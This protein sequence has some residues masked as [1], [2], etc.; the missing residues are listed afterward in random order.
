MTMSRMRTLLAVSFTCT[1][2]W[3][4]HTNFH[5]HSHG[6][7]WPTDTIVG[8]GH[9]VTESRPV[10]G[11]SAISVSSAAR[12]VIVQ[13]DV[14]SLSVTAEDNILPLVQAEVVG[15]RLVLGLAAHSSISTTREIVFQVSAR[16]VSAID[17]TGATRVEVTN[18]DADSV[19]LHVSGASEVTAAGRVKDL[20]VE[21]SGSVRCQLE[22]LAS[23][24]AVADVSGSSY[25]RLRVE[26][27]LAATASGTSVVEY[28]GN[29][30]VVANV[31]GL[32]AVRR[33]GS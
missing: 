32:S 19:S 28:Y 33:L 15:G 9:V 30:V 25:A 17:A 3:G 20:R 14:E 22:G 6:T 29:P 11:F 26:D 2:A 31:S 7:I 16:T 1:L 10:S 8:S 23:H 24:S 12:L 4:C 21:I 18:L 13:S 5:S 27:S